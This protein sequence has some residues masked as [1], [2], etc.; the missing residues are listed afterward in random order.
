MEINCPTIKK[1]IP[2]SFNGAITFS[3]WKSTGE[4]IRGDTSDGF[5]GAIT[6]SLWK[7]EHYEISII[8]FDVLQWGHNFFVMEITIE[9]Q[10]TRTKRCFNGAITF[11]LWK[12][13]FTNEGVRGAAGFNGAITFSLWKYM[14]SSK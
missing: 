4:D 7:F 2:D 1:I 11:S 9:T 3:L 5:N 13:K 12:L 6:F 10:I 8:E 14:G